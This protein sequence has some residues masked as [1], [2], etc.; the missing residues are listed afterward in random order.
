[1]PWQK[2]FPD[3]KVPRKIQALVEAGILKDKT[4]REDFAPHFE[5]ALSDGSEIVLWID[6]PDPEK[7][8]I[9]GAGRF[10]VE[11]YIPRSL[12]MTVMETDDTEE[13]VETI[14]GYLRSRGFRRL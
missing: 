4:R 8:F 1:M 7:S 10:G 2:W 5:T 11:L 6:H 9:S 3:H 12:P 13:A 14:H